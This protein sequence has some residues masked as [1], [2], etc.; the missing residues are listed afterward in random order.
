MNENENMI[1]FEEI[2]NDGAVEVFND[3]ERSGGGIVGKIVIGTLIAGVTAAAVAYHKTKD[4]REAKKI[5]KL[6]AKGYKIYAP[7]NEVV[8]EES[9]LVEFE[10][11]NGVEV[12]K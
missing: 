11:V 7:T 5:E 12:K 6:R 2:E 3:T 4:K 9:D 1:V 8:L 10:E